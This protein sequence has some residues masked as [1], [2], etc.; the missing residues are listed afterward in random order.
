M[1]R[2]CMPV[3]VFADN[4][5]HS[6]DSCA[7]VAIKQAQTLAKF[8]HSHDVKMYIVPHGPDLDNILENTPR[9]MTCV[10]CKRNMLRLA[11]HIAVMEEADC[12]VTGEIIGEQASQTTQNLRAI[13]SAVCDYP[14]LRPC[15]GDDKVDIEKLARKIGTY[16]FAS[17]SVSCCNLAPEYPVIRSNIDDVQSAE[18]KMDLSILEEE[19]SHAKII[20]LGKDS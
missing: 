12:I 16:K 18:E 10:F 6:D 5:P 17:E 8:I 4:I 15:A 13:E 20:I 1:K 11:R 14:I 19:I 3:I 2:G 9:K 7:D